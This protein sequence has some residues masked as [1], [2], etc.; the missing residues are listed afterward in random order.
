MY[1]D[2]HLLKIKFSNNCQLNFRKIT[3]N[4]NKNFISFDESLEKSDFKI[5]FLKNAVIGGSFDY[6]HYGHKVK[7]YKKFRKSLIQSISSF[8]VVQLFF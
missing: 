6:L 3:P 8:L 1:Y 7:Y 2:E 4:G 5:F